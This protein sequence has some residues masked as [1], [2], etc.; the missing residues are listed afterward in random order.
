MLVKDLNELY[1]S[2]SALTA[3]KNCP[4][5]FKRRYLDGLYWPSDWGGD[6]EQKRVVE[7]GKLFHLLAQRYYSS[8]EIP[9][10]KEIIPENVKEW[11]EELKKFRPYHEQATFLP[12]HEIRVND[13]GIKLVAKYDL[14]YI[15]NDDRLI[16][17]DWKTNKTRPLTTYY[18]KHLQTIIYRYVLVKSGGAYSNRGS[19]HPG[20][21]TMI[22]WNPRYPSYQEPLVYSQR[23]FEKDE[24]MITRLINEI[25]GLEKDEFLATGEKAC[26]YCEY[27]P[28]CHGE[29]AVQV[30][31]DEEDMDFDLDWEA[32]DEIQF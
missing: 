30:E 29:R 23:Q 11:F 17:Y 31:I 9:P 12:E 28:I 14:L 19:I 26:K 32:V 25:K 6:E 20:Q 16:I 27:R 7:Q 8:G 2:Q 22:Y 13:S 1:F 21:V 10:N 5:K 4:L 3:Y 24:K 18:L 15:D